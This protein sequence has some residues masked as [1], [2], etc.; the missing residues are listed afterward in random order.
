MLRWIM[1]IVAGMG[2]ALVTYGAFYNHFNPHPK[3]PQ[4]PDPVLAAQMIPLELA[5]G[6]LA[7]WWAWRSFGYRLEQAPASDVQERM[8]LRLAYRRGG[9]IDLEQLDRVPLTAADLRP[10]LD[11]LVSQGK[12]ELLG[13]NRYK[14]L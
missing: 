9:E 7:A 12:F 14:L 4:M 1:T 3:P 6:V 8:V 11:Q 5:L 13:P 2:T 10:I